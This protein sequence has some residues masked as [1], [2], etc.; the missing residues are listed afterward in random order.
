[1]SESP[2]KLATFKDIVTSVYVSGHSEIPRLEIVLDNLKGCADNMSMS[3]AKDGPT[4]SCVIR[5]EGGHQLKNVRFLHNEFSE[6]DLRYFNRMAQAGA[7]D[8]DLSAKEERSMNGVAMV[9]VQYD[10]EAR[11]DVIDLIRRKYKYHPECTDAQRRHIAKT[12]QMPTDI[13]R[14]DQN[15]DN[16][17]FVPKHIYDYYR[18]EHEKTKSRDRPFSAV[19]HPF[20]VATRMVNRASNHFANSAKSAMEIEQK[21]IWTHPAGINVGAVSSKSSQNSLNKVR[22]AWLEITVNHIGE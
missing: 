17:L 20:G 9:S 15:H 16:V 11:H 18:A 21:K 5:C 13:L 6:D 2:E 3:D 8:I 10:P 7:K 12:K 19:A 1:M 22:Q 14:I 4:Q